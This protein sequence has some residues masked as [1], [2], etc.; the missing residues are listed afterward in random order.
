MKV[1]KIVSRLSN[2]KKSIW[3]KQAG[4]DHLQ[5]DTKPMEPKPSPQSVLQADDLTGNATMYRCI[6]YLNR[7]VY[8]FVLLAEDLDKG[9]KHALKLIDLNFAQSK[10]AER[11]ILNHF[12]LKHPHII[13][14]EEI[15]IT[16]NHLVL[17]MEYADRG[18]LFSYIKDKGGLGEGLSRWFFQQL[19]FGVNFCHQM[20]IVNRDIKPENILLSSLKDGKMI[21][22]LS[23]FGFSKDI[24][25]DSAPK[26]RLGTAMYIAPEVIKNLSDEEYDGRQSDVWSCGVVLY[27]MLTGRYPFLPENDLQSSHKHARS[28]GARQVQCLF[29][30]TL[31]N[32]FKKIPEVSEEC[33]ALLTSMLEPEPQKRATVFDIMS[34]TWFNATLGKEFD[35]FNDRV[36][37]KL[38]ESPRVTCDTVVKVKELLHGTRKHSD[39]SKFSLT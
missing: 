31:S 20:G 13:K 32:N 30:R 2:A 3:E 5:S 21:L 6:K 27:V 16:T 22:K 36:I 23:D 11:E 10:Y 4:L 39:T 25:N 37:H 15:F 18:D 7:G 29:E 12:K 28:I 9:K 24:K 1:L 35:T 34:C 14:L 38:M 33:N 19:M 26:T 17:V 8:G